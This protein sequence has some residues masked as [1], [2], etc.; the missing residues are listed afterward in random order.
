MMAVYKNSLG[1][2]SLNAIIYDSLKKK[3]KDAARLLC[4]DADHLVIFTI[5]YQTLRKEMGDDD[6]T[7]TLS[8]VSIKSSHP[9]TT[10]LAH[11]VKFHGIG[12]DSTPG[13]FAVG[14]VAS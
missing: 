13:G 3:K 11:S 7:H 9:P 1:T 12:P 5:P 14:R 6:A 10:L 8:S 2:L 4:I